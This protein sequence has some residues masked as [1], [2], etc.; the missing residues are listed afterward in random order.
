M[1][2]AEKLTGEDKWEQRTDGMKK[3]TGKEKRG[4]M[5]RE[6]GVGKGEGILEGS[7]NEQFVRNY[8]LST[9]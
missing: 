4:E 5:D 6:W 2:V 7:I 9:R 1:C 3:Q 8:W